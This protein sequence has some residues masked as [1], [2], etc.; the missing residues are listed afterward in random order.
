MVSPIHKDGGKTE[1]SNYRPIA[2]LP[3]L[4]KLLE[5]IVHEQVSTHLR[6]INYFNEAQSGFR[7]GHS[8]TTCLVSFLSNI[9]DNIE[10]GVVSG[11]LFL[12]LKKAFDSVDHCMMEQKLEAAGLTES[13]VSWFR[14]YLGGRTQVTKVNNVLSDKK[15]VSYGVPQGSKLGPLMFI[16]FVNDLPGNISAGP[17]YLYADDTA[18]T[19]TAANQEQL[20]RKLT[21]ALRESITWMNKNSLTMNIKKT[22]IMCFGTNHTLKMVQDIKIEQGG[23]EV[24]IVDRFKYLG[25]IL[26]L[27]LKFDKHVDYV[28]RKVVG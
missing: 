16:I 3:I 15:T 17:S 27:Y 8:T 28:K 6:Y 25:V 20:E 24:E 12:D 4:S 5:H 1:P 23:Q 18:I 2:L 9:F 13:A 21:Q 26:D 14:S 11:V 22:K 7:K 19:V 10:N